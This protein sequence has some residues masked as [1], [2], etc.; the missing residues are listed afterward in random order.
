MKTQPAYLVIDTFG[1]R[2][3]I[4]HVRA[5]WP[6]L[7]AGQIVVRIAIEIPDALI[8]QIQQVV[9]ED[10]GAMTLAVEPVEIEAA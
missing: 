9:I 2:P 1:R 8:P 6:T 7:Y 10:L 5:K 4:S 3:T